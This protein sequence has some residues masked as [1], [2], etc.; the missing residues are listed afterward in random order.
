[1]FVNQTIMRLDVDNDYVRVGVIIFGNSAE[2]SI[3]F[4]R[5]NANRNTLMRRVGDLTVIRGS[6]N[7]R[8]A[9]NLASDVFRTDE[10]VRQGAQNI[11]IILTDGNPTSDVR[12]T[13]QAIQELKTTGEGV[14]I[15]PVATSPDV[16][17]EWLRELAT[18]S[19]PDLRDDPN[20]ARLGTH[21]FRDINLRNM[22]NTIDQIFAR[23]LI[24]LLNY[25]CPQVLSPSKIFYFSIGYPC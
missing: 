17:E 2:E 13:R 3:R 24:S 20:N 4:G 16:N 21:F 11:V 23:R 7:L 15:I 9:M 12:L 14:E 1:M 18:I 8:S 6:T 19:D 22:Q 5:Y 10:D 25:D